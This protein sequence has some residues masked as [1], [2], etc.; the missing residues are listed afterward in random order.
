M[1]RVVV[2]LCG[3][4]SFVCAQA[5]GAQ[6]H[7]AARLHA[8]VN[9][10]TVTPRVLIIGA[11]PDDDDAQLITWLSRG[12][13]IETAY[14]SLTRGEAGANFVGAETGSALGVVRT[15][16]T[17]A[18][19]RI[20]G[21]V[22]Y[23]T[24]AYDFGLSKN[25]DDAFKH[26]TKKELLADVV[27]IVRSFRPHVIVAVFSDSVPDA[28]GQH[29]AAAILARE[30]FDA[31]GDTA[32]FPA[33]GAY[34]PPWQPL[35]LYRQP[36][37]LSRP[38]PGEVHMDLGE[39]DVVSGRAL[40]DIALDSRAQHRSQGLTLGVLQRST[41]TSVQ[42]VASH[43][44]DTAS[45]GERSIFD[46]IDTSLARLAIGAPAGLADSLRALVSAADSVR[47][48]IDLAHPDGVVPLLARASRIAT[49]IRRSAVSCRHPLPE[50]AAPLAPAT[51]MCDGR[52]LDLDASIDLVLSRANE[53]LLL[54]SGLS[55]ETA[56]DRE[57]VA[58]NDTVPVTVTMYNRGRRSVAIG[59]I[60]MAGGVPGR[61]N[62]TVVP[63]D[64]AGR[65]FR[66]VTGLPNSHPWWLG[67]RNGDFF[68]RAMSSLDGIERAD[69]LA[70]EATSIAAV[71]LPEGMRRGSDVTVTVEIEGVTVTKSL[72]PAVFRVGDPLLGVQTRAI[73][74]TPAVSLAFERTMEWI[75]AGRPVARQMRLAVKSF[76][77]KVQSFKLNVIAPKGVR[78]DSV[79]ETI[80][81]EPREQ[82]ELF[83]RGRA[84]VDTGVHVFAVIGNAA[85]G[86]RFTTGFRT[87][88]YP[89]LPPLRFFRS[90]GEYL[91]A[92]DITVPSSLNVL[93]VAGS[94]D[95][96]PNALK[97]VGVPAAVVSVEDLLSIDLSKFTTLIIGPRVFEASPSLVDQR[98]RFLEF[99][100]QGGTVV[101]LQHAALPTRVLPFPITMPRPM[102]EHVAS[103]M[104]PIQLI[105]PKA[106]VVTWPNVIG[107]S[108]WRVW[109]SER[110]RF[111]PSK[112][113]PRWSTV[114]ETHD[115]G[116]NPNPNTLLVGKVG[117]GTYIYTTL[118]LVE[119]IEVGVPGALRLLV[120]L[121]S[122]GLIPDA[123][124]TAR[125]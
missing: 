64:S 33:A 27:T 99:A 88:Q 25:A 58:M 26:W 68:P 123:K 60:S 121:A 107:P 55:F 49:A 4:I 11:H 38:R 96:T 94:A 122:A 105:D 17:L 20:D 41:L 93:Y 111:V 32:R 103:P 70:P 86:S 7:G 87:L 62:P 117:K 89:H 63:P 30:V 72:G 125:R 67:T 102:P 109:A 48:L 39:Y 114:I 69:E 59:D 52:A 42:R 12:R 8:L 85:D 66:L 78:L 16:E 98:G 54:A 83:L 101:I 21:G 43:V 3:A 124:N 24:R 9:G 22:Q 19:R 44:K 61:M 113:D 115:V 104:A 34:G 108:D 74:G 40:A 84:L 6:D 116:E 119:Q 71:A 47:V 36:L 118:S 10:L 56:A 2:S 29:A 75:P 23:F 18:A 28:N 46:G 80:T 90:S 53:A 13:F 81:L 92:V 77:D 51:G 106:R 65:Q 95:D 82:R 1:R 31:G 73:A 97:G 35:E 5:V 45:M 110:A 15:A 57:L 120:N 91:R 14:L 76:S 100:R 50:A 79:P 112:I 37:K